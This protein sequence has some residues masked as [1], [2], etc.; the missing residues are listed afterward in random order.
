MRLTSSIVGEAVDAADELDVARAPRRVGAHGLHVFADRELRLPRRPTTAAGAR[1]ATAPRS[2]RP[3]AALRL[4]VDD[5]RVEQRSRGEHAAVVVDLQRADAGRE[6]EDAGH[7]RV[8]RAHAMSAW[9]RKRR[10]RSRTGRPVFDEQVVVAGAAVGTT[11][12]AA[13]LGAP[14]H[15]IGRG[16]E[17]AA[18]R[19]ARR[20][21]PRRRASGASVVSIASCAARS[22]RASASVEQA[23]AH[24]V[25][26]LELAD[27]PQLA[28]AT[29]VSRADEAAE[30]RPVGAE[31]DRHVA[32][33][34]DRA[35][36]VGVVVDVRRVQAGLAAVAARPC[37][38]RADQADA[39]AAELKCT[40]YGGSEERRDVVV[41]EEVRRAVRA[42]EHAELPVRAS[43]AGAAR[44]RAA[45]RADASALASRRRST[46]PARSAPAAVAAEAPEREGRAAA[47]DRAARRSR[48]APRDR[49]AVRRPSTRAERKRLARRDRDRRQPRHRLAVERAP[50]C[51]RR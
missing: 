47:E 33:E 38:L 40:S 48:R 50:A 22:A 18:R 3:P 27:L 24:L 11:A 19:R 43:A 23:E 16:G 6:V 46:S 36:R 15:R 49:R 12:R 28:P 8:A 13:G 34:V 25:A 31:D 29:M 26:G 20:A 39:G 45:R 42:V 10:S 14:Q 4:L 7:V 35:D 5:Q 17:R 21:A 37:R 9:T 1:C 41:G 51:R 32:G 30:A 44:A 2:R